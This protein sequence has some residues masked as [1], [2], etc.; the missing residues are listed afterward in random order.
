MSLQAVNSTERIETF[1]LR[2]FLPSQSGFLPLDFLPSNYLVISASQFSFSKLLQPLGPYT[3]LW[4]P[5][6]GILLLLRVPP[7]PTLVHLLHPF[8]WSEDVD[9]WFSPVWCWEQREKC[10]SLCGLL[11]IALSPCY[12]CAC[13]PMKISSLCWDWSS[14]PAGSEWEAG[15]ELWFGSSAHH[16]AP[17]KTQFNLQ[18]NKIIWLLRQGIYV[19]TWALV[20]IF[21]QRL[22]SRAI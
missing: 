20:E 9:C 10:L 16:P 8:L 5:P 1:P 15:A 19:S 12:C 14:V 11:T 6:L 4:L 2:T 17:G 13:V 21:S 7:F 18:Q 3:R 22:Y